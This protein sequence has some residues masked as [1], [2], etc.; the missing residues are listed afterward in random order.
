MSPRNLG[1]SFNSPIFINS[2]LKRRL[3]CGTD[4]GKP[5]VGLL[6]LVF[7][8]RHLGDSHSLATATFKVGTWPVER[9]RQPFLA[10]WSHELSHLHLGFSHLLA[11]GLDPSLSL[12]SRL[13]HLL[14]L[15][16]GPDGDQL[17]TQSAT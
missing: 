6:G 1:H 4:A 3:V 7:G 11:I 10:P 13:S 12:A 15:L 14:T 5:G 2:W 8:P 17:V 16:Q 9:L